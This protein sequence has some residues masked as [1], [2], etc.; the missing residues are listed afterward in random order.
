MFVAVHGDNPKSA[1]ALAQ[2]CAVAVTLAASSSCPRPA[3]QLERVVLPP[4]AAELSKEDERRPVV[5]LPLVQRSGL[6]VLRGLY[7]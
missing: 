2:R 5:R 6:L 1:R 7:R 3:L 4:G